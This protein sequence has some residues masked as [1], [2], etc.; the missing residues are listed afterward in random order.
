MKNRGL[1]L[2]V[3]L[4]SIL[5]SNVVSAHDRDRQHHSRGLSDR[6]FY[7]NG[8]PSTA[9]FELGKFLFFDKVISGNQN[10]SCAACHHVLTDSGDGLSLPVGEGGRGLGVTRDTGSGTDAIHERV[11]RN[12]P[13]VYNLGAKAWT[14]MF[15]DGRIAVDPS[16]PSGFLNP[17]GDDLP[18]GLDNPLAVQAM[19]PVTSAAEMAG[20]VGENDIADAADSGNLAGPNGVWEILAQRL[21]AIPEYVD[22]FIAAYDDVTTAADITY[23]HAAN[24]I[25]AYEAVAFRA[26]N[27]PYNRFLRGDRNAM[28]DDAQKGMKLFFGKARCS[29]CHNG[30]LLTDLEF[31]AIAMP[32]FGPGKGDGFD[33]NEDYGR[34]R[35]TGDAVDRYKFRT[36]TLHNVALTGPWGH[37]GAYDT[38]EG[39]VRH[40]LD[41]VDS[42][43][44]YDIAEAVLPSRTDLDD[45]DDNALALDIRDAIAAVN[46]LPSRRIRQKEFAYLMEFLNAL[47]DPDTIDIRRFMPRRVPSGLT[48][49]D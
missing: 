18:L 40:H 19:F 33:G 21:Q 9:K 14:I 41:P 42:L 4:F 6:D 30:E 39:V 26:D 5:S 32:Q 48:L 49:A 38:L 29:R 20:Q 46:E 34:E 25:A 17:A 28:T 2:T 43:Y 24:A 36:P 22:L 23:V 35:V 44:A 47:T 13:P 45:L 37:D 10:I 31:H 16:Q 1:F 3:I 12:A 15:H 7:D 27:S 11:P 8:A